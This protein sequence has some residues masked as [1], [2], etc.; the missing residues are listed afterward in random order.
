VITSPR[1]IGLALLTCSVALAQQP[2]HT[3]TVR[4]EAGQVLLDGKVFDA[5]CVPVDAVI[6]GELYVACADGRVRT[7]DGADDPPSRLSLR[8][9]HRFLRE[10]VVQGKLLGLSVE[11]GQ[12]QVRYAPVD[13]LPPASL[14]PLPPAAPDATSRFTVLEVNGIEVVVSLGSEHGLEE[15]ATVALGEPPAGTH[16]K[17][18]VVGIVTEV[19]PG[20]AVVKVGLGEQVK[21]GDPVRLTKRDV[22]GSM[23]APP[24]FGEVWSVTAGLRIVPIFSAG[25]LGVL[26]NVGVAWRPKTPFALQLNVFPL[27]AVA[28]SNGVGGNFG[29]S[30]EALVD[31]Q[32]FA[33][34]LGPSVEQVA[35]YDSAPPW[36]Y[37]TG[38]AFGLT[39]VMRVG[40]LD[41]LNFSVRNHLAF[42]GYLQWSGLEGAAQIPLA[43]T[44]WLV[45]R[46]GFG[47]S[48]YW[49]EA[50]V[51]I[52][53]KG[54]G[55]AGTW[56][57]TPTVGFAGIYMS[58][59]PSVGAGV[60]YR[61]AAGDAGN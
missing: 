29:G 50:G 43:R 19:S 9:N 52:A 55:G 17:A 51:R 41:G 11:G 36:S 8:Q 44:W 13:A 14:P 30:F 3:C 5:R 46:G 25:G 15:D 53:I 40:A 18:P 4:V 49:G 22:T 27:A 60:E 24:R 21:V 16:G 47:S 34:G 1:A 39:Q 23:V 28:S 31:S 20:R 2:Q 48:F 6:L 38:F 10:R 61:F 42:N 37:R 59:G 7:F 58:A 33:V 12:V 54:T 57:L 56:F 32:Y 26:L 35:I 45:A